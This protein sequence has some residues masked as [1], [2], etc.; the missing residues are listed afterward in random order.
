MSELPSF[1]TFS[2]GTLGT[3]FDSAGVMR[4][5][6]HNLLTYSE[7]FDNAAWSKALSSVSANASTSPTG[8]SSA[9]LVVT[10]NG[11]DL[12]L[13]DA[14]G[15]VTQTK[16]V[17]ASTPWTLSVYAKA[18][19]FTAIR[20]R[21]GASSGC[22]A[23]V[24]L[25][26]GSVV[27][28]NRTSAQMNVTATDIG[29]GW[30]RV[31]ATRTTG[32]AETACAVNIKPGG[33]TGDGTSGIYLWG[34][35]L[36]QGSYAYPY[37]ATTSSAYYGPRFTYDPAT[38]EPLGYLAEGQRT[39]LLTYSEQFDN[40]AWTQNNVTVTANAA[41]SPNGYLTADAVIASASLNT[42]KELQQ[43]S[44]V[45]SGVTYT[46]SAFVKDAG[47]RYVQ[48]VGQSG[49]FGTFYVNFD[50]QSGTE[51]AFD[52]GT[53]TVVGRG[54]SEIG[55]GWFRVYCSVTCL[56]TT[57]GRMALNIIPDAS[58]VRG[59][60]WSGDG[61]SGI[62]LWGAQLEAASFP[63]S[64]IPTTTASATRNADSLTI[65]GTAATSRIN[66]TEGT[67][68]A[69][70]RLTNVSDSCVAAINDGTNNERH[71]MYVASDVRMIT[72]DGGAAQCNII[73]GAATANL[74][75]RAAIAYKLNDCGTSLNGAAA[76]TDATATMPTCTRFEFGQYVS[77][78]PL[79]GTIAR[80]KY[81][82][83]RLTDAQLASIT[84]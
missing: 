16:S 61:T 31:V 43:G 69:Q 71:L 36:T 54:I 41:T 58:S 76:V 53:S 56:S 20:L 12:N 18:A 28:E 70:F 65:T 83:I 79:F 51:V 14:N 33:T 25:S 68:W 38:L 1:C 84:A 39:N 45:T 24:S 2:R 4:F 11:V 29:N 23:V 15:G 6:D 8:D 19:G 81:W 22:R 21:E 47:Y 40:A 66:N 3:C 78:S 13:D 32:A 17:A 46:Y 49:I 52:A 37:R 60:A 62:Y 55:D 74:T 73:A 44:S 67:L 10:N 26:D 9:D 48:L 59:V 7:Q 35:Q 5:C 77:S 34:A 27:Y 72:T 63:S 50:L 42:F 82:P 75:S 64:Y 57:S 80:V 30:W